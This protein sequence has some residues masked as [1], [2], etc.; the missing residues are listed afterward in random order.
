MGYHIRVAIPGNRRFWHLAVVAATTACGSHARPPTV[1]R[2]GPALGAVF[3]VAALGADSGGVRRAV[4]RAFGT[5]ARVDS[6]LWDGRSSSE[7]ARLGRRAGDGPQPVSEVVL[8]VVREVLEVGRRT[9]G[10]V[11]PL[12]R[13]VPG[14]AVDTVRHTVAIPRGGELSLSRVS[15]G[16]ALDAALADL[17][18]PVDSAILSLG[19]LYLTRTAGIRTVGIAD[20]DNSLRPMA[21]LTL[22]AGVWGVSIV[23]PMEET[24]PV[25]DPRTGRPA[26]RVRVAAAVAPRA[27]TA[28]AWSLAGYVLGCD[29]ALVR[30]AD[31]GVDLVCGDDRGVRWTPRL[32]GRVAL[33]PT[34]SGAP[35]GTGPGPG[36]APTPA[37]GAAPNAPT[38]RA[39]TSGSPR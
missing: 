28:A 4:D 39:P 32:E 5:V 20:P 9:A 37:G 1:S 15:R 11:S 34:D 19:G 21:R 33:L 23:S 35:A 22:G 24:D 31:A 7:L 26:D 30:A 8:A 29:S 10:A 3:S 13:A 38:T 17:S 14:F 16:Y 2:A 36:R 6:A 18:D 25:D 12:D 27:A